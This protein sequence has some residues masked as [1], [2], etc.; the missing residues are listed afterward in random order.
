[1][2]LFWAFALGG[3]SEAG[4]DAS[5]AVIVGPGVGARHLSAETLNL[6]FRRKQTF[7]ADGS[8]IH[9]V[10][11]PAGNTLRRNFSLH[12]L[13]MS[14]EALEEYWRDVYFHGV[15]PPHVLASEKAVVM[16]VGSTP[17]AIGYVSDCPADERVTVVMTVGDVP[18]CPR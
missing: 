1:M 13:G 6:I 5:F 8:R 4:A 12:V 7:W 16:F 2:L 18:N 11:L 10:N 17:G 14:P 3:A 15:L 9:P